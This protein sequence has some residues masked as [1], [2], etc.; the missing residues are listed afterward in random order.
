MFVS[1]S[2]YRIAQ[3]RQEESCMAQIEN[4]SEKRS[5]WQNFSVTI[6]LRNSKNNVIV[7]ATN[8]SSLILYVIVFLIQ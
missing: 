5:P 8:I 2:R 4:V 1:S 3:S 7:Y 6:R